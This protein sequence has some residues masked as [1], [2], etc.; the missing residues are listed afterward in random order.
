M[1]SSYI[2]FSSIDLKARICIQNR[3]L[4]VVF[5]LCILLIETK[6]S[7]GIGNKHTVKKLT[8]YFGVLRPNI[9]ANEIW[10]SQTRKICRPIVLQYEITGV[11][12]YEFKLKDKATHVRFVPS[13]YYSAIRLANH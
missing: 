13:T 9:S 3:D 11:N 2:P 10:G 12:Y 7:A 5:H 6:F 1:K 4:K 8:N